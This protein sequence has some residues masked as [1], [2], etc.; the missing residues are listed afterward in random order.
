MTI[1]GFDERVIVLA[2]K[3][4]LPTARIAMFVMYF[5]FGILKVFGLSPA[6]SLAEALTGKTIGLQYFDAA[7]LALAIIECII[8]ILFLFPKLTRFA[9]PLLLGHLVM[10]CSPLVLLPGEVWT[11]PFVPSLEGQYI[12]K[13]I[14]L[15]A[16]MLGIIATTTPL[17]KK[18]KRAYTTV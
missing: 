2:K 17:T 10:V 1:Q 9:V 13:N 14:A 8:G 5:Y 12:I 16:L 18:T 6:T 3:W 15:V 7:F 4:A 11:H